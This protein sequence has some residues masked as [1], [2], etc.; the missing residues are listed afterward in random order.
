[1]FEKLLTIGRK[2]GII[3]AQS[4]RK[5]QKQKAIKRILSHEDDEDE[6]RN[7]GWK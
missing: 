4:K 7:D 6:E 5:A 2:C 1:M 3:R